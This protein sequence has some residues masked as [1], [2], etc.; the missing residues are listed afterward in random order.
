MSFALNAYTG[1]IRATPND[2]DASF[3]AAGLSAPP[4][5]RHVTNSPPRRVAR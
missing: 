5:C 3:T 4:P 2:S 1:L